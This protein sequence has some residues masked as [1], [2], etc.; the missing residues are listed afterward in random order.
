M[1]NGLKSVKMSTAIFIVLA[2]AV[3]G[4]MVV[5]LGKNTTNQATE[6]LTISRAEAEG[7]FAN[8]NDTIVS[9]AEVQRAIKEQ[10]SLCLVKTNKKPRGISLSG[11]RA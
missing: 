10:E 5:S 3:L 11:A 1:D 8:Y 9:G 2:I 7:L 4:F 6:G